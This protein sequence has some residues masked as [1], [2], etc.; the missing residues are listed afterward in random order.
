MRES[1]NLEFKEQITNT[2]LKTVSAYAN[3]G[4]GKIIFGR[5]DNGEIVGIDDPVNACLNIENKIND[6]IK[7]NPNYDLSIDEKNKLVILTVNK[8]TDAP[9]F[10]KS[11]AY[12]RNDSATV[13]IDSVELSRLILVSKNISFDSLISAKQNLKFDTLQ[14]ALIRE[15]DIKKITSDILVTLNLKKADSGYTNAGALLADQNDF[16]GIDLVRFGENINVMLD[17]QKYEHI[18]ILKEYQLALEKYRQYYQREEIHGSKRIIIETVPEKAFREAIA[19]ALV[20]RTWDV[21]AQIK[22]SMFDDRIEITSPGGLPEGISKQEYLAGQISILRNPIIAGIFFRLGLIEQFGTGVQR[23]FSEYQNSI[24]KP[25]FLIFDN[26]ITV[27]LPI[28]QTEPVDLSE[29][30]QKLYQLLKDKELSS[31]EL[32]KSSGFGKTK[33]LK[34]LNSLISAGYITKV[35]KGR[36]T[37]YRVAK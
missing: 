5:A 3:Y 25:Q 32:V 18:S 8:G 37:K 9:Y 10:Y 33:V 16:R 27:K 28:L 22:V 17:R 26:S 35:G 12:K 24:V 15:L 1:K 14:E 19:N 11:K 20:H 36:S 4:T 7:P 29:N 13:E 30:E 31:T 21:N 6:S 2:F 23:I 34:L